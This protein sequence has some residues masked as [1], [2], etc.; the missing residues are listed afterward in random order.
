[1]Q[2][3]E[4]TLGYMKIVTPKTNRDSGVT[5]YKYVNGKRVVAETER[6]DGAKYHVG[7]MESTIKRHHQLMQ[8]QYFMNR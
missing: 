6:L 7:D 5:K 1:M 2:K 4:S 8:R 3:A